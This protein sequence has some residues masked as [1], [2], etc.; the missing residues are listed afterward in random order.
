M[1]I[2]FIC[3]YF[4]PEMGAPA[5]RTFEHARYWVRHGHDVTV[6]CAFPNHPTG[7]VPEQ[8]KGHWRVR[9]EHEG[10]QVIR[11]WLY[12]TPNRGVLKR[13]LSFI[14]FLLSAIWTGW[15]HA[16]K[17]DV[18]AGTSPQLLCALAGWLVA[19]RHRKPFVLEIRDLW[20]KQIIDLGV[21]RQGWIIALLKRLEMFLY[22]K[23]KRIVTVTDAM[24]TDLEARG[25]APDK[26]R[27]VCNG[28]EEDFFKPAPHA[29]ALR[30]SQGWND[31]TVV[32][33]IGTHGLSQGLG[34]VIEAA[35][36]L[37]DHPEVQ[38]VLAGHGAEKA[39]VESLTQEKKLK[40]VAHFPIQPKEDM[41]EWYATSDI[42][43]VPLKHRD[44]FLT[45][46]PSK[47]YE[48]MACGRPAILGAGGQALVTLEA[49]GGGIA[50][51]PENPSALAEAI[52][53]LAND[54]E[55]CRRLG[56]QGRE[57]VLKHHTRS[58]LAEDML[59]AMTLEDDIQ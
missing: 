25:I 2:L 7:I 9:E 16:P 57:Y 59:E 11:C 52:L 32:L 33:Y 3:Q 34:T 26:L 55:Q 48:I 20:P 5:A 51:D 14:S 12:A 44:V 53:T 46:V 50:V 40:N 21:I 45:N 17:C 19:W 1:R 8:Y 31:K 54:P 37:Q 56:R 22:R 15:F 6:L 30:A 27:V 13:S 10:V 41:P 58:R 35:E 43:L 24:R 36:Q 42:C 18:V 47:L 4:P 38:F 29:T 28:V 49:S 39:L 23:A